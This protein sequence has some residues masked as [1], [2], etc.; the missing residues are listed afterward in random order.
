MPAP[1]F[2]DE[3]WLKEG[4]KLNRFLVFVIAEY[5]PAGG[6]WDLALSTDDYGEVRSLLKRLR[7]NPKTPTQTYC[8][9][10]VF[11]CDERRIIHSETLKESAGQ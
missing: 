10:Q 9:A 4:L 7:K 5:Y 6:L 3:D 2:T 8:A 11:D 1:D